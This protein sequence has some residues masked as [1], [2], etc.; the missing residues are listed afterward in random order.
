AEFLGP[1]AV[2]PYVV[3]ASV[4]DATGAG[5][6]L[7]PGPAHRLAGVVDVGRV[8]VLGDACRRVC[9]RHGIRSWVRGRH[10]ARAH[11]GA[12]QETVRRGA[13]GRWGGCPPADGDTAR[14]RRRDR[15]RW[16]ADHWRASA[17]LAI[18][19]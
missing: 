7:C 15:R 11:R 1:G 4:A 2:E 3:G 9:L 19:C 10:G 14:E 8:G 6:P 13:T 16:A 17:Y 5:R 12:V 18:M